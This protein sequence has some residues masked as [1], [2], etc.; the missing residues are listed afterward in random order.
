MVECKKKSNSQENASQRDFW[1]STA[2]RV[3]KDSFEGEKAVLFRL[4]SCPFLFVK[5]M[6]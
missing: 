4:Q 5:I 6:M 1:K 3:E 2:L